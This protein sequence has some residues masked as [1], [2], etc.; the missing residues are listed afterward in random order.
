[1]TNPLYD[2]F[3]GFDS[4]VNQGPIVRF[5][6]NRNLNEHLPLLASQDTDA[7]S[8][9]QRAFPNQ[10][11]SLHAASTD[12]STCSITMRPTAPVYQETTF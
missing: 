11:E 4:F 8:E 9:R 10:A 1:M 5:S 12:S 7:I 6:T 2:A 3:E